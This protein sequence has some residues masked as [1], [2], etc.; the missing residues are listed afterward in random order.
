MGIRTILLPKCRRTA[1]ILH[2][3]DSTNNALYSM[4]KA[5]QYLRECCLISRKILSKLFIL[6]FVPL[7]CSRQANNLCSWILNLN[8]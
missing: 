7:K 8:S 4:P 1:F 2:K 6:L 3:K 5:L